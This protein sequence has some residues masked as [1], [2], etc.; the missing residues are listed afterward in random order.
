MMLA[1]ALLLTGVDHILLGVPDLLTGMKAFEQATGVKPVY[2]GKHPGRG[3]ENALVS[4]G[5]GIYLELI[6]PQQQPDHT[7][8]FTRQ[9]AAL[10][11]PTLVGWAAHTKDI[12]A[13]REKLRKDG[14]T[15]S[16]LRPGSRLTPAGT[17]LE[18]TT[19]SVDKPQIDT[20]PFFIQWGA[21][22]IHPSKSSPGGCHVKSFEIQDPQAKDLNRL[23]KDA[24]VASSDKPHMRLVLRCGEREAVFTSD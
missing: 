24:S 8:D 10:K 13:L 11:K 5:D 19:L 6:A 20:A 15:V 12:A 3:T 4:L 1:M 16:D 21:K 18:W 14:F 17:R 7:D 2:G 22:S 9:L 23:L